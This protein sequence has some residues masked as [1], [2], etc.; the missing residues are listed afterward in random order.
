LRFRRSHALAGGVL[1]AVVG[2]GMA[3]ASAHVSTSSLPPKTR[4]E[5]ANLLARE[6]AV[7]ADLNAFNKRGRSASVA[8]IAAKLKSDENAQALDEIALNTDLSVQPPAAAAPTTGAVLLNQ[9]GSGEDSTQQFTVPETAKGW[10]VNWSYNCATFGGSG[11]FDYSVNVGPT[12]NFDDDG[13]NQLGAGGSG[14]QH[15]YDTGTFNLI[16]DSECDWTIEAVS[17]S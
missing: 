17:G 5:I 14:T 6:K 2:A 15:Y 8:A 12:I 16:V 1:L 13:P 3:G 11:D 7:E 9:S 4:S 10:H